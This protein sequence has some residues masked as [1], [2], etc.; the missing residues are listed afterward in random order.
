M[1]SRSSLADLLFRHGIAVFVACAATCLAVL[2]SRGIN[3]SPD[4]WS[5]W[6]GSVSLLNGDGYRYFGGHPIMA[7][8]PLYSVSLAFAQW[9]LGISGRTLAASLLATFLAAALAL[10]SANRFVGRRVGHDMTSHLALTLSS[11]AGLAF[12]AQCF[13]GLLAETLAIAIYMFAVGLAM[14]LLANPVPGRKVRWLALSVLLCLLPLTKNSSLAWLP[15][16]GVLPFVVRDAAST[17]RRLARSAVLLGF[18]VGV[19]IAMRLALGQTG[20]HADRTGGIGEALAINM[21]EAFL[22]FAESLGPMGIAPIGLVG[23]AAAVVLIGSALFS[24]LT[25]GESRGLL[26]W[27]ALNIA[28]TAAASAALLS[29]AALPDT[30]RG[31]FIWPCVLILFIFLGVSVATMK[32]LL[33]RYLGLAVLAVAALSHWSRLGVLAM[34][35]PAPNG[36]PTLTISPTMRSGP[37]RPLPDGRVLVA[38]PTYPWTPRD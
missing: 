35:P 26:L 2:L 23:L 38:P 30:L 9:P 11:A 25:R 16:F 21:R 7:W 10:V 22:G 17:T 27:L 6:E 32:P 24:N 19:W 8:P 12:M 37:D 13:R 4:G 34:H 29:L 3:L 5:Y 18:P 33:L 28:L 15:A 36:L 14:R 31:R 20:S 1:N